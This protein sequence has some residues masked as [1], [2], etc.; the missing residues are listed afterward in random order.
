MECDN[1]TFGRRSDR[2]FY[3]TAM[4]DDFIQPGPVSIPR[5]EEFKCRYEKWRR[6]AP[7]SLARF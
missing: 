5:E 2:Q 3:F 6:P 4:S 7:P 1:K